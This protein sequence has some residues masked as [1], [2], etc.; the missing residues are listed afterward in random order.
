M[1]ESRSGSGRIRRAAVWGLAVLTGVLPLL[2]A[3]AW[4]ALPATPVP[5]LVKTM[6]TSPFPG[7]DVSMR[8]HEGL[9]HV[10]RDNAVWL[11]DDDGRSIYEVDATT[12]QLRRR[13]RG[14]VIAA[15]PQL[16][17]AQT[18]GLTRT[19]DLQAVA[20]DRARDVLYV[21]SGRC[22]APELQP[23][24]YR[25]TRSGGRLELD[26]WQ[27]L[28]PQVQVA[29]AAWDPADGQLYIGADSS[30]YSYSYAT[31]TLGPAFGVGVNN[32]YGLGFTPDGRDLFV[33][34]PPARITRVDFPSR[35]VVPGWTLDLSSQGV[36]DARGA[37][38]V[39]DRLWISDGYDARA[40]GDPLAHAVFIFSLDGS[41]TPPTGPSPTPPPP[42][43]QPRGK[44]LVAN[45]GFEKSLKG[46]DSG[47]KSDLD[48]VKG[49]HSGKRA[50]RVERT[51]G[52]GKIQLKDVPG[53]VT[54]TAT[55]TYTATMWV[56]STD[57]KSTLKLRL[58]ELQSGKTLAT[59]VSPVKLTKKWSK[60]SVALK[61]TR[62]GA[63]A[64]QVSA[65]VK[66]AAKGKSF[67][68]DDVSLVL[69]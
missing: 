39:D 24:A 26:S 45:N 56:R 3:P 65:T 69:G 54:T 21:F 28:P 8:D 14:S 68:A 20:Y 63:T 18:A 4:A 58:R 61:I 44:N 41:T 62:P 48:R 10:A 47:P 17:G 49:G 33:T 30:L 35:T 53:W 40:A 42:T 36:L 31:N 57:T 7:S 16:G 27:P 60:V 43:D 52:K 37:E 55:G 50:A 25:L 6:R 23:T 19:D 22:C 2:V 66:G 46:W 11:V 1:D 64:L 51:K 67:D 38:V 32:I 15:T 29:A 9:V 5:T 59:K 12:G 34:S 13:I